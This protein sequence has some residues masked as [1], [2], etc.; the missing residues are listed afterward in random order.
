M[1]AAG[2][3]A[4][5]SGRVRHRRVDRR[6]ALVRRERGHGGHLVPGDRAV[7]G[8]DGEAAAPA[9]HRAGDVDLR[10]LRRR[11]VGRCAAAGP[12]HELARSDG[13]GVG[14][15]PGGRGRPGGRGGRRRGRA[16]AHHARSASAALAVVD[17]PRLRGVPRPAA[18]HL[19]GEGGDGRRLPPRRGR[20]AHVLGGRL[21]R[22]VLPRH[23]R[24][25]PGDARP[26]PGGR[27]A[28]AGHRTLGPLRP[29][30]AGAGRGEHGAVRIRAGRPV[31]RSAPG[32][33]RPPS[34]GVRGGRRGRGGR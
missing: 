4:G 33:L 15:A 29:T 34:A 16:V 30:A 20:R 32:L 28:R 31:G 2:L 6:A 10:A 27:A 3:V 1:G 8:G 5:G 13:A 7:A 22:R 21:V 25:A 23:D 24:A 26:G 14:A 11:A 18:G 19:R 17:D 12:P 9:G